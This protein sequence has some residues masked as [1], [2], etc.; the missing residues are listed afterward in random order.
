MK[1]KVLLV[2]DDAMV[3]S[4]LKRRLRKQFHI[5]TALSGEEAID[6]VRDNGPFAVIVSDFHMPGMNGIEFLSQV[7]ETHPDTVRM[8]LTGSDDISTAINAVNEG[9]IYKFHPKPC[10]AEILGTAIQEGISEFRKTT[11]D[12]THLKKC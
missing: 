11:T 1:D 4:G 7:K 10:P 9:S 3:L 5:E 6:K 2:D 12:Q 8:M